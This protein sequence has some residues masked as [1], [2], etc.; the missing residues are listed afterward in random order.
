MV[1]ERFHK[2]HVSAN[3]CRHMSSS[4]ARR[5]RPGSWQDEIAGARQPVVLLAACCIIFGSINVILGPS[6]SRDLV[7][8]Q[9][10][11]SPA[12]ARAIAAGW[13]ADELRRFELH[14]YIDAVFP[15]FYALLL[16]RRARAILPHSPMRTVL[17]GAATLAASCDLVENGLH[18]SALPDFEAAPNW[19]LRAAAIFAIVKWAIFTPT[20]LLLMPFSPLS[21]TLEK[22]IPQRRLTER[23]EKVFEDLKK[24]SR[25]SERQR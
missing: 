18:Y 23:M 2:R 4:S 5:R 25:R 24:D 13:S 19:K 10:S 14:L 15:F 17:I 8:L 11:L 21:A 22:T 7:L 16:R 9:L 12:D 1:R 20:V 6:L 3:L